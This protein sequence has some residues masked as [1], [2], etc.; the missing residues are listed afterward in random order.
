MP[1]PVK[2]V[3][4]KPAAKKRTTPKRPSS[5]PNVRAHQMMGEHMAKFETSV[6]PW[7]KAP[8]TPAPEP[9]VTPPHGDTFKAQLSAHMKKIGTK[10]G[11]ASGA[12]RM[13]SLSDDQRREIASKAARARWAKTSDTSK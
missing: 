3:A 5:D 6:K 12:S 10:G 1:K 2:K 8:A 11:N 4:P 7:D 9:D 13:T